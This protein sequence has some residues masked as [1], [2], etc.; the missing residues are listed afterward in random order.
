MRIVLDAMGSDSAPGP[1]LAAAA[2]AHTRWGEPLTL[3]GPRELLESHAEASAF[4]VVDAPEILEMTDK[5][6]EAARQKPL[7]SMAVGMDLL[8]RGQADAFVT[9]GNTGGAMATALFKLGRI[10]GVKRPALGPVFPVR[11]GGTVVVDIGANVECKPEYL[12]Q[13]AIMGSIYAE[14]VLNRPN[15]RVGLLSTGEEEGKGNDLV[16]QSAPLLRAAD[17]N[18]VG[19]LEPKDLYAGK[20]DVVVTDGFTGNVF[21]KTSE[22]VA[23]LLVE[24][25]RT[26][27]RA[28]PISA[29]G[30]WLAR[31]AFKRVS[32]LLDPSEYGAV[33]LL[34][35]DGL[36]FIG[37]GRSTDRALLNAVRVAREAVSAGLLQ[38]LRA[39]LAIALSVVAG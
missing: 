25:L 15:P 8:K 31:P 7:S 19:N 14:L 4:E 16:R 20:A 34:G 37:H 6:A 17:L 24:W 26:E 3:T 30:G 29:A 23:A 28:S 32:R 10:P 5:P 1:E 33:P 39:R 27:I 11:T 21:L 22:A 36:V 18:F 13:F 38:A 12:L 35:V 2:L 9:A